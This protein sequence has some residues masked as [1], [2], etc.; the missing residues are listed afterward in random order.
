MTTKPKTAGTKAKNNHGN[1]PQSRVPDAL[2]GDTMTLAGVTFPIPTLDDLPRSL[3]RAVRQAQIKYAMPASGDRSGG[4][5]DMYGLS[6][7]VGEMAAKFLGVNLDLDDDTVP[8]DEAD[9]QDALVTMLGL[10]ILTPV[11][12]HDEAGDNPNDAPPEE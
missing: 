8:Q 12:G 4:R 3:R 11:T 7:E 10:R 2:T 6:F 9:E 5:F 1:A